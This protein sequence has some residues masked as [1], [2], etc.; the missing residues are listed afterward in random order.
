[1]Q[2]HSNVQRL[3]GMSCLASA[4]TWR[5]EAEHLRD[6]AKASCLT[7][8]QRATLLREAEAADRQADWWL[9]ALEAA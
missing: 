4:R 7:A 2:D 8:S 9:D 3:A 6:H 1:M 5:S